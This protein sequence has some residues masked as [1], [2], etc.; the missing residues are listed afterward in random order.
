[1]ERESI[2]GLSNLFE[3]Y[4]KNGGALY[5]KALREKWGALGTVMKAGAAVMLAAVLLLSIVGCNSDGGS[6]SEPIPTVTVTPPPGDTSPDRLVVYS[7]YP[8]NEPLWPSGAG[9]YALLDGLEV[10]FVFTD[11]NHPEKTTKTVVKGDEWKGGDDADYQY[12]FKGVRS[13]PLT[14]PVKYTAEAGQREVQVYHDN[15]DSLE[16][17]MTVT[18]PAVLPLD[19]IMVT[20]TVKEVFEDDLFMDGLDIK[21]VGMYSSA[22][23]QD[24]W[25]SSSPQVGN[26]LTNREVPLTANGFPNV[27]L[28]KDSRALRVYGVTNDVL[29]LI[30]VPTATTGAGGGQITVGAYGEKYLKVP[31]EKIWLV[32]S[33]EWVGDITWPDIYEDSPI[34]TQQMA[35]DAAALRAKYDS[36]PIGG[37]DPNNSSIGVSG[38]DADVESKGRL[39]AWT[40]PNAVAN[41]R[42]GLR[43]TYMDERGTLRQVQEPRDYRYFTRWAEI[44]NGFRMSYGKPVEVSDIDGTLTGGPLPLYR[45]FKDDG[46]TPL[47]DTPAPTPSPNGINSITKNVIS[48]PGWGTS[49]RP[50]EYTGYTPWAFNPA[51]GNV[52]GYYYFGAPVT[53]QAP[54][55]QL[56]T[57]DIAQKANLTSSGRTPYASN[58]GGLTWSEPV[59][60]SLPVAVS[61]NVQ[62]LAAYALGQVYDIKGTYNATS[63]PT[64][65]AKQPSTVNLGAGSGGPAVPFAT[66]NLSSPAMYD[67]INAIP[68][69]NA[70]PGHGQFRYRIDVIMYDVNKTPAPG[71]LSPGQSVTTPL[72]SAEDPTAGVQTRVYRTYKTYNSYTDSW[73]ASPTT[74]T[75]PPYRQ[76][77]TPGFGST[78]G[79]QLIRTR[80]TVRFDTP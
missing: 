66:G 31:V 26:K 27:V 48:P 59:D 62:A 20:S 38:S 43:V 28:D 5:M 73:D 57:V 42:P 36:A 40:I 60:G 15:G 47:W 21:A 1:M 67:G 53:L 10:T 3:G 8:W 17:M 7:M 37:W 25:P 30:P 55:Y 69:T 2:K 71:L 58:G 41:A 49:A 79:F 51:D 74:L 9:G 76:S 56:Q 46:S 34:V 16:V 33:V 72:A 22:V 63:V 45:F 50:V 13:R 64:S 4:L 70:R 35:T 29:N 78:S 24:F 80:P 11:A 44:M 18:L 12:L 52:Y 23:N 39:V 68:A 14:G 54:I 19:G 65:A 32:R 6:D 61:G 75:W 77:S